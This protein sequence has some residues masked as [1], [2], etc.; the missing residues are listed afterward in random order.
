MSHSFF[1][2]ELLQILQNPLLILTVL[3]LFLSVW[4]GVQALFPK[5]VRSGQE[6]YDRFWLNLGIG[7]ALLVVVWFVGWLW[8]QFKDIR[9]WGEL[10]V[11]LPATTLALAGS[12]SLARRIGSGMQHPTDKEQP[13][14]RTL[15]G[16]LV[17]AGTMLVPLVNYVTITIVLASGLGA[18]FRTLQKMRAEHKSEP[19]D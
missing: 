14:R 17:L 7:L 15:R 9:P 19:E 10:F 6:S 4:V 2:F 5:F 12:A 16:G 8:H 11:A 13:W 1:T 3:F 18:T